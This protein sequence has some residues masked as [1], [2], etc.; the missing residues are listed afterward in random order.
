MNEWSPRRYDT[1]MADVQ[2]GING[3]I[4]TTQTDW[5]MQE[6]V[7][8]HTRCYVLYVIHLRIQIAGLALAKVC[9]LNPTS[10]SFHIIETALRTG[11]SSHN[12]HHAEKWRTTHGN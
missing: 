1:A 2:K 6:H 9:G 4:Y 5:I 8:Y 11:A 12:L 3:A 7:T 10:P